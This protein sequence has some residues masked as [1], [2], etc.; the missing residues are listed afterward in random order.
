MVRRYLDLLA[1]DG[2][3]SDERACYLDKE[4]GSAASKGLRMWFGKKGV[5]KLIKAAKVIRTPFGGETRDDDPDRVADVPAT[6][7]RAD[8]ADPPYNALVFDASCY[9]GTL[10]RSLSDLAISVVIPLY[11][12]AE[13]LPNAI[14]S[15]EWQT[16]KPKELIVVDDGSSDDS[17]AVVERLSAEVPLTFLRKEN[18]GQSSARNYGVRH[19]NGDLIAFLDQDDIWYP[20]HLEKLAEP[21]LEPRYPPLGWV[22]SNLDFTVEGKLIF[23]G[24][25]TK[26]GVEH[27]K[28]SLVRCLG[29]DMRVLPSA[30]LISRNAFDSA[31][32]FD[33]RLLGFEDDD[34]FLRIFC[35]GYGN[36]FVDEPL[37]QWRQHKNNAG[38]STRM[39]K[40][41]TIYMRKLVEAFPDD[42]LIQ[43]HYVRDV[44]GPR[45]I[46]TIIDQYRHA[47]AMGDSELVEATVD[48]LS[49]I[50]RHAPSAIP[51]LVDRMGS[52]HR[53]AVEIEDTAQ[54][55]AMAR[56]LDALSC[57]RGATD[58]R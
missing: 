15:V 31:N 22:Y 9:L 17:I 38:R 4:D 13:H 11:N 10:G 6:T 57:Q 49:V 43:H 7:K 24:Y 37:S 18:G 5:E 41:R 29:E 35:L 25:V 50:E 40:S 58:T 14:R 1:F 21:F 45:F 16:L 48:C 44:I 36:V 3:H 8:P 53:R 33:E 56:L 27:P 55:E 34:L 51:G 12:G 26:V 19:S 52:E 47:V 28:R 46:G 20:Q 23:V 42:L 39:A 30:S 2:E 32:G 54:A